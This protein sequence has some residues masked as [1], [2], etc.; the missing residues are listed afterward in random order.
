VAVN[1][2]ATLTVAATPTAVVT[3]NAG[4]T[5]NGTGGLSAGSSLAVA[6]TVAPGGPATFSSFAV[7]GPVQFQAG[8]NYAWKVSQLP[9]NGTAGTHWDLLTAT[10]TLTGSATAAS[11]FQITVTAPGTVPGFDPAA[12][13]S[14]TVASFTGGNALTTSAFTLTAVGWTGANSLAGGHFTLTTTPTDLVVTFVPVPEPATAFVVSVVGFSLAGA[15]RLRRK[16]DREC[17]VAA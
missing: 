14:W 7:G 2:G 1:A 4:G 12:T 9:A 17:A 3:V 6:G 5:V 11:P 13:Y 16:Q 8:G 15:V 10:G